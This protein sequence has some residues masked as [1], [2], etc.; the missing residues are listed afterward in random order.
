M[1]AIYNDA[2]ARTTGTFDTEPRTWTQADAWFSRH[3]ARHPVLVADNNGTVVAWASLSPWSD[4]GGYA[5]TSEA[6]VYVAEAARGQGLA[7]TMLDELLR[8]GRA[9]G[10][11]QVLARIS[12]DNEASLRLHARRGFVEVGRLRRVGEKFGRVLDVQILQL[13]LEDA[14]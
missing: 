5:R 11:A 9:M 4:R 8:L 3:D 10:T 12:T 13:S 7:G 1:T 14:S 2:V 6:S